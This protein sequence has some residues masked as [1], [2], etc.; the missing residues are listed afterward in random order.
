VAVLYAKF[1]PVYAALG[2]P[3]SSD[4]LDKQE[5]RALLFN[6][7]GDAK[8]PAMLA[9]ARTLAD[10]IYTTPNS[11][12]NVDPAFQNSAIAVAAA[13]G[14][15]ALYE[16]ILT[17][18]KTLANP[19]QQTQALFTLAEFEDPALV[20]RTLEY[21]VSGAVRNQDSWILLAKLLQNPVTQTQT[22]NYIRDNWE[23]VHAQF[24]TNSGVRVVAATGSFCTVSQRDEVTSFFKTH[25]VD[26]SE[27]TLAKAVKSIDDCIQLRAAQQP[28]LQ[29]WLAANSA[30]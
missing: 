14:D 20:T 3:S 9:Q 24:T 23:K 18:S 5:L 25:A 17:A 4:S 7:L 16:K 15:T 22:W 1:A 8:D 30:R 11:N 29:Q 13:H 12:T 27:R 6:F 19:E 21:V 2:K 26:A 28:S 10:K